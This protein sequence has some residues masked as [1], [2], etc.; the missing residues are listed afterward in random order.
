MGTQGMMPPALSPENYTFLQQYIQK[1]SGIALGNDK[2]YL[3]KSRLQ[4]IV[5]QQRLKSLDELCGRL[6][7]N[8]PE[9]LRRAVVESMTTH[10]TLFFRDPAVFEMLR[11]E[12]IPELVKARAASKTL[13]IWCA[14]CSSGQEP[15]SLAMLLVEMGLTGWNPQILGT[16]L[17]SQILARAQSGRFLQIEVN[18]G[19]PASLLV[20]YFQ[21]EGLDWQIKDTVRRMVRF[22]AFD[23]RH[24]M[25]GLGPYDLI[26]C[27]N[28]LI[29]FESDTRKKIL[30]GLRKSLA[31][32]GYLLLGASETTFTLDDGFLRKT[33]RNSV[34][35]QT[36]PAEAL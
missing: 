21:R 4:P 36:P 30:A 1:E 17:S 11:G 18:R 7:A 20:K 10:E 16:D 14:A 9:A 26:L 8:P 31:P 22:T 27:R 28:V 35:Y 32:G 24:N 15:Y 23:L 5:E 25:Q 29:Y 2:L 34:V 6:R 33:M 19:L 12:L 3:L 13:R